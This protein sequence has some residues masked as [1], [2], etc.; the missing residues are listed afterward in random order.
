VGGDTP[1]LFINMS[2]F[3]APV[4]SYGGGITVLLIFGC[5]LGYAANL[6]EPAMEIL[7]TKVQNVTQ[8]EFSKRMFVH[9]ASVGVGTG[10]VLGLIKIIY[11]IYI[12]WFLL[13]LYVFT[14][15]LSFFSTN[16][17]LH[18][19]WDS[20][21]ITTG[22]VTV[23]L[24]MGIGVAVAIEMKNYDGF[25]VLA[26]A[27]VCP[28]TAV[29]SINMVIGF[30]FPKSSKA[31]EY[32]DLSNVPSDSHPEITKD[33]EQNQNEHL[34]DN[35]HPFQQQTDTDTDIPLSPT[36]RNMSNYG[37]TTEGWRGY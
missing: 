6:A 5:L 7:G 2:K 16:S 31:V 3:Q 36:S 37:S 25:G 27:S 24:I 33:L 29:L 9:S 20:G 12:L 32:V 22:P 34:Y 11:D 15:F 14:V 21:A 1:H 17:I 13:P 19:A 26:L 4:M 23:P 18:I 28:I 10:V 30:C 35:D 8:G